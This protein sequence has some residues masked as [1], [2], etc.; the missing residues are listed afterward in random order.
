MN[1]W[2]RQPDGAYVH[3][4]MIVWR[5]KRWNIATAQ[6]DGADGWYPGHVLLM[7]VPTMRDAQTLADAHTD[8]RIDLAAHA[9]A[10]TDAQV[11][12]SRTWG[13]YA[14]VYRHHW[15]C[16]CGASG[17]CESARDGLRERIEHVLGNIRPRV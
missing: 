13:G 12:G 4:A 8:G 7:D 5:F 14:P 11:A 10:W 16:S 9:S 17:E 1:G 2:T 3:G 6:A 15:Y